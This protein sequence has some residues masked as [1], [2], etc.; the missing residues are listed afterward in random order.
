MPLDHTTYTILKTS[1]QYLTHL[2]LEKKKAFSPVLEN[3]MRDT[4]FSQQIDVQK[5]I[6]IEMKMT[7]M[8]KMK[9][10][11]DVMMMKIMMTTMTTAT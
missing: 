6:Q 1:H 5:T 10:M 2:K 11:T 9:K 4:K 7:V 3:L 8:K